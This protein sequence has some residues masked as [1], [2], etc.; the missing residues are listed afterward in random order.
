MRPKLDQH[1]DYFIVIAL[2]AVCYL[3]FFHQLGGIGFLGPDEPRYA[4][5]AR[6]MYET[7]DYITPRLHGE[8]WFEKPAL[9]YWFAA[10]GFALFGVGETGARFPSAI[11]ATLSVFLIYWCGR[12]LFTRGIGF[13]AAL[14]LASSAGFFGLARAASMDM[15]LTAA[16]TG[17]LVFFLFGMDAEEGARRWY[18]YGFYAALGVGVMAKGPV[19]V[20][21]P[22]LALAFFL[23]WRGGY[24]EWRRWHPEGILVTL[25]VAAP[26]YIAVTWVNGWEFIDVF[27]INQ[28]LQRFASEMHGHQ[29]PFYFFIPVLLLMMFPWT[30]LLIPALRRRFSRSEQ[31]ILVWALAPFVFFSLSGSK[32]PAYILPMAPPIAL[33]CAREIVSEKTRAFQVAVLCQAV[34]SIA[35]GI[36]AGFFGDA[37]NVNLEMYGFFLAGASFLAAAALVA[38]AIWMP[39]PA[40]GAFNATMMAIVVL[41]ITSAIFPS[42]PTV[43]TMEPW[44]EE[45]ERFVSDGQPVILY[46]PDRWMDYGLRYYRDNN[47]VTVLSGEELARLAGSGTRLLC[48]AESRMLDELSTGDDVA[49]EV[50]HSIGNQVAFWAWKP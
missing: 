45:L 15:P 32:L 34:L 41:V 37:I 26:W 23:L 4:A 50:V 47:A 40:L 29:E 11:G 28:N 44:A 6:G 17:A 46:K 12:R 38:L 22:V 10:L 43:E 48:I 18:F 3:M 7:G 24:G 9:M 36:T 14:I 42:G 8:V 31:L 39:A 13:G 16:L 49:I 21:L 35:I 20:L 27:I 5:V 19:A 30:F 33:L 1:L 2:A 25:L